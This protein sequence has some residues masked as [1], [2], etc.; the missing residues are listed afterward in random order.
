MRMEILRGNRKMSTKKSAASA[1]GHLNISR[2]KRYY[3]K[4]R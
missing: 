4:M 3:S 2:S 1:S